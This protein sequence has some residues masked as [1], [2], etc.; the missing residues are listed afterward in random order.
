MDEQFA[1][2]DQ[3]IRQLQDVE[4]SEQRFLLLGEL[5]DLIEQI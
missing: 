2:V 4:T 3:L 1:Q 5:Y